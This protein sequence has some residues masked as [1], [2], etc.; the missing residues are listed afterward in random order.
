MFLIFSYLNYL[1]SGYSRDDPNIWPGAGRVPTV[2]LFLRLLQVPALQMP[3]Q[4]KQTAFPS[5]FFKSLLPSGF[6]LVLLHYT[7]GGGGG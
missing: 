1:F 4:R 5:A 7:G 6:L 3:P 2:Q